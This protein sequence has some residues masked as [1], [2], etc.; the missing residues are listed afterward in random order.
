MKDSFNLLREVK[1][2]FLNNLHVLHLYS[3]LVII[4]LLWSVKNTDVVILKLTNKAVLDRFVN[5][6][7]YFYKIIINIYS[8]DNYKNK[9]N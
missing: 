4:E 6:N 2:Y 5:Q 9:S 7:I 8:T 3:M 1:Y